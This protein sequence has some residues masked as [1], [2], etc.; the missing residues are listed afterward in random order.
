MPSSVAENATAAGTVVATDA[1]SGD[2]VTYEITGGADQA[3]FSINSASGEL[4]FDPAPNFETPTDVASTSPSNAAANNEY[5]VVVTATG[6]TGTR[7]ITYGANDHRHRDQ[8]VN[9][10]GT[11]TLDSAQPVVGTALTADPD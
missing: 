4:T 7:A 11:V 2:N 9:E 3:K 6:G 1:D 8:P 5:I 10:E